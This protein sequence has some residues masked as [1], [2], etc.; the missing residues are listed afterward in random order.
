MSRWSFLAAAILSEVSATLSLRAALDH[1]AWYAVVTV[2]YVTSFFAM[3]QVLTLG[4]PLGVAYGIWGATGVATTAI[5]AVPLFGDP[6]TLTMAVGIA[7][8]IAGVVL[9]EVGHHQATQC[10]DPKAAP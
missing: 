8:L 9:V 7:I 5:L 10:S 4:L 1:P 3:G 6:F 2:G